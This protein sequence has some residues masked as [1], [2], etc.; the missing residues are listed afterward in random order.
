MAEEKSPSKIKQFITQCCLG[1]SH[2]FNLTHWKHVVELESGS[3]K[4]FYSTD[5]RTDD[6]FTSIGELTEV[7]PFI[8]LPQ[9]SPNA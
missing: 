1:Y 4:T 3:I 8:E 7:L 2:D 6:G 9:E 5:S